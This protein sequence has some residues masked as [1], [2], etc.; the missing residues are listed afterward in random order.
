M[1]NEI[2]FSQWR[3]ICGFSANSFFYI[4][5]KILY[6]HRWSY[7]IQANKNPLLA[8]KMAMTRF[9]IWGYFLS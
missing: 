4:L 9:S 7:L 8:A 5:N 6:L 2:R 3:Q 1:K